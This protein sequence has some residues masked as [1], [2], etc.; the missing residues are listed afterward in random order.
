MIFNVFLFCLNNL[1]SGNVESRI[2]QKVIGTFFT[3][4]PDHRD[5]GLK[6]QDS[7]IYYIKRAFDNRLENLE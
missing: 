2:Q 4:L 3:I 5:K 6:G 7:L 1:L